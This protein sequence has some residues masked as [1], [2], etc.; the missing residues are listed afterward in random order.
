MIRRRSDV[1]I[2]GSGAA[3]LLTAYYLA[4]RNISVSVITKGY[5][6]T[7][8]SSGCFD[9]LGML[10]NTF[11]ESFIDGYEQLP[12]NHPYKIV[13]MNKLNTL[14]NLFDSAINE[15]KELLTL[16][17]GDIKRNIKVITFF[18][19]IKP[20]ALIQKSMRGSI[21]HH[22]GN[23]I[24]LGFRN[25]YDYNPNLQAKMLL[26][27]AKIVGYTGIRARGEKINL[28]INI[29]SIQ[30]LPVLLRKREIFERFIK[31]LERVM[32]EHSP[33]SILIPPIFDN[34]QDLEEIQ[35]KA[36]LF[37]TPSPTPYRAGLRLNRLLWRMV[38]KSNVPIFHVRELKV[39]IKDRA[40][41]RIIAI[42]D[43]KEIEFIS[44]SFVLATGD[45]V[46]GGLRVVN[47]D[48]NLNKALIDTVFGLKI[49]NLGKSAFSDDIFDK[50][51]LNK[52]GFKVNEDLQPINES[53]TSLLD[54]LYVAGSIIGGYDMNEEKSGLGIPLVT[55][56]K[57]YKVL[58]KELG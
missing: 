34:I 48:K 4:K 9:V 55:S 46:G 12:D 56:F 3:G 23:Y 50:H 39:D 40:V 52:F 37:E 11:L 24:F 5:G 42:S 22:D 31:A 26:S 14:I 28:E 25:V 19:S 30:F 36:P 53:N 47:E 16:Y 8:M 49:T 58:E 18:G 6:A 32:N 33:D 44:N 1:L 43:E 13:S 57:L 17:T 51:Y 41:S 54:N 29:P 2:I 7:A 20:T 38:E 27:F 45:L 21:L 15:A 35:K 10:D